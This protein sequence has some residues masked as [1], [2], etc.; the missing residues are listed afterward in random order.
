MDIKLEKFN[1]LEPTAYIRKK[2]YVDKSTPIR[3][4]TGVP[5]LEFKTVS[6]E[7]IDWRITGAAG[8]VGKLGKNYLRQVESSMPDGTYGKQVAA[9]LSNSTARTGT[10]NSGTATNIGFRFNAN[11]ANIAPSDIG[12]IVLSDGENE[13]ELEIFSGHLRSLWIDEDGGYPLTVQCGDDGTGRIVVYESGDLSALGK[14]CYTKKVDITPDTDYTFERIGG[15]ENVKIQYYTSKEVGSVNTLWSQP[16]NLKSIPGNQTPNRNIEQWTTMNSSRR[17]WESSTVCTYLDSRPATY[18]FCS[19]YADLQPGRYKVIAEGYGKNWGYTYMRNTDMSRDQ[20][21]YMA[22]IAENDDVIIP[23][24]MIFQDT[25]LQ[26]HHEEYEFTISVP[27]KVGLYFKAI[28]LARYDYGNCTRFMIVDY[29]VQAEP[30]TVDISGG[31]TLSGETCWEPYRYTLPVIVSNYNYSQ[32][33]KVEFDLG[34]SP[35]GA[36]DTIDF[37]TTHI[38]IPTFIG[39]NKIT[40]DT[41]ITPEIYLKYRRYEED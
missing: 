37:A 12:K 17:Y 25:S 32:F 6:E 40:V 21:P 20:T 24:T 18:E 10:F 27:T 7:L 5:P 33:R 35:L 34:T 39:K 13:T 3:E 14:W 19:Y 38:P 30:F 22:L 9:V 23:R 26:F 4:L 11:D 16:E 8:G 1:P 15:I 31:G 29:D 41:E 28:N 36:N 2:I